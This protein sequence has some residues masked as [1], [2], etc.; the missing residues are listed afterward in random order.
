M[1]ALN[2]SI[3]LATNISNAGL[4]NR[5]RFT[6]SALSLAES[7]GRKFQYAWPQSAKF[8][9]SLDSLWNFDHTEISWSDSVEISKSV[10]Y[11]AKAEDLDNEDPI[12]NLRSGDP[13]TLPAGA[14]SWFERFRELTPTEVIR[15]GVISTFADLRGEPYVGVSIR[16]HSQSHAKT[17][18]ASPVSWYLKRM[19]EIVREFPNIKFFISCDVPEVQ[20]HIMSLYPNSV[21]LTEKGDYNSAEG[22]VASIV[23]LYL[24]ASSNYMLVPYWSSFPIMAWELAGRKIVMENSQ[25]GQQDIDIRNLPLAAD[26][27]FPSKRSSTVI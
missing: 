21:G 23:D 12:W 25:N 6:L 8:K 5:M 16:A 13:L 1:N 20:Q 26:P 14:P 27:L 15:K 18:E 4:G 24:L 3:L 22:V 10:P 2:D 17:A 7:T 9:P 19:E 11:V